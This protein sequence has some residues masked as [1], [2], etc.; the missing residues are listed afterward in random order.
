M[1]NSLHYGIYSL[2]YINKTIF[3]CDSPYKG[4]KEVVVIVTIG[5]IPISI[6]ELKRE[7]D[8]NIERDN[9]AFF[10]GRHKE[11]S[12]KENERCLRR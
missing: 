2:F 5:P 3:T 6:S 4:V 1:L 9:E 7:R 10:K 11:G 8:K 12:R